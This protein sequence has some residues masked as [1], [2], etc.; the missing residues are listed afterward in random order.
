MSRVQ[1]A[2]SSNASDEHDGAQ[3]RGSV[4]G[5]RN[6]IA[7]Q[8]AVKLARACYDL[9]DRFP[10]SERYGLT[11]QMRRAASSVHLNIAEGYGFGTPAGFVKHLR[12]ARGSVCEVLSVLYFAQ[13]HQILADVG[14]VPEQ[15]DE[16][17]RVIYGLLRSIEVKYNL[18]P[19][20]PDDPTLR[21]R[22][23]RARRAS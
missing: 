21:V 8:K 20:Y 15:A 3:Q 13:D 22:S 16:A 6:L 17:A 4:R 12:H 9:S 18:E 1:K 19:G 14:Q 11:S 5:F 23:G 2:V 7:W 10:A